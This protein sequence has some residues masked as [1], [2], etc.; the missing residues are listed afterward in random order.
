MTDLTHS[1]AWRALAEHAD[2]L[3]GASLCDLF[4][5]DPRRFERFSLR[6]G[7]LLFDY[8]KNRITGETMR[9]LIE[10]ARQRDVVGWRDRMFSGDKINLTEGRAVLHV[11]LRNRGDRAIRVD[12]RD[13]MPGV[14]SV[15]ARM[16]TFTDAVRSG[17]WK[18]HTGKPTTDIVN[19]G[20]GGSDLGPKMASEALRPYWRP[21]LSAY[22]VSNVDGTD[23]SETLHKIDPETTLF[24][25]ASKTFTTQET[26]A[27]AHTARRFLVDKLG[28][29]ASVARHFVALSTNADR[30]RGFGIAPENTS[31]IFQQ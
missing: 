11:A 19:I 4:A 7:D 23:I 21:G 27:N 9:L 28:G 2:Q 10:L 16:R 6:L 13:V 5:E 12:G 1:A 22:F 31:N 29:D 26:M 18:G 20:I 17:N 3:R 30:V 14:K 15:L 8:S 24:I 25:V